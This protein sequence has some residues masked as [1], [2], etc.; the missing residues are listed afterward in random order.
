MLMDI[1]AMVCCPR[2]FGSTLSS[3]EHFQLNVALTMETQ[4]VEKNY[5]RDEVDI[6]WWTRCVGFLLGGYSGGA[7]PQVW[8][9][10]ALTPAALC[11]RWRRFWF[12]GAVTRC[13][14]L[15]G[16]SRSRHY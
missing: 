5:A 12:I 7:E 1:A 11:W 2:R 15:V 9:A 6:G 3:A 8:S 4:P 16:C 10:L 14:E 13:E